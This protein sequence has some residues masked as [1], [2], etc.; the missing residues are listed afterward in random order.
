MPLDKLLH[1]SLSANLAFGFSAVL[2]HFG[3]PPVHAAWIGASAALS[4]GLAKELLWD[5]GLHRGTPDPFDFAADAVG[6]A[7]GLVAFGLT[8]NF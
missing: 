2:V 8:L 5:L 1:A 3:I 4:L 7:A 6:T